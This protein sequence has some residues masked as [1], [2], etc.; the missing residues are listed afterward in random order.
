MIKFWKKKRRRDRYETIPWSPQEFSQSNY[1]TL[2]DSTRS[3]L[4]ASGDDDW[5][6]SSARPIFTLHPSARG[7]SYEDFLRTR[8]Q[9]RQWDGPYSGR[10][11]HFD[12]GE[13]RAEV[14]PVRRAMQVIG[15]IALTAV[16]YVSFQSEQPMAQ[17]VQAFVKTSLTQDSNFAAIPAWWRENVADRLAVPTVSTGTN[18]RAPLSPPPFVLPVQGTVK[19]PFDGNEQQ[20][21]TFQAA[22]G[23]PVKAARQG[24]VEKV[25]RT[26]DD[27][28]VTINHGTAGRTIYSHLSS[29]S[30]KAEAWVQSGQ[31]IGALKTKEDRSELFFAFQRDGQ[32]VDPD[33]I[34]EL[35]AN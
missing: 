3:S 7:R 34:L 15:A 1:E 10:R 2:S 11:F 20:G 16:L 25:E 17:K 33:E 22:A 27:Y 23:S 28:T 8:S 12:D 31:E 21:I 9:S 26:A 4:F 18:G 30:V 29:V 35:P 13:Y 32:Y 5:D 19:V 6:V 24:V 14:N